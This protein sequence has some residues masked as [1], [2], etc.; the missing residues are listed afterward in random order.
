MR[1]TEV[2]NIKR[3]LKGSIYVSSGTTAHCFKLKDGRLIKL[4]RDTYRKRLL[5]QHNDMFE[6]LEYT[7]NISND[8]Y[9]GADEIITSNGEVVA[10]IMPY[11]KGRTLGRMNRKNTVKTVLEQY[12]TLL[13]DTYKVSEEKYT[14]KDMHDRNI[15]YSPVDGFKVID[16]DGGK[17]SRLDNMDILKVSNARTIKETVLKGILGVP[18]KYNMEFIPYELRRLFENDSDNIDSILNYICEYIKEDNP[19]VSNLKRNQN[20]LLSKSLR[21]ELYYY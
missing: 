2:D 15:I 19:S 3:I 5:F 18:Y 7:S 8:S 1:I 14:I 17:K 10:Y 21:E 12:K 6:L 9:I 20:K 13:E 16:L 4:Y 11:I